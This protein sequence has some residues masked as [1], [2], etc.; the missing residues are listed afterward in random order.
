MLSLLTHLQVRGQLTARELAQRLEVDERTVQRDVQ[1]LAAAGVPVRSVRGPAGGYRLEGGYRTRLNGVGPDEAAA[2]AFLG[3]HGPAQ[4]LGLSKVLDAARTKVL[5]SL[6]GEARQRAQ[7]SADRFHL[8]PVRWYGRP[9]PTPRLADLADAVWRDRRARIG[10]VRRGELADRTID[11]LGLA[12]ASG[13]WYLVALRDGQ[14]R[15]YRVSRVRTVEVLDEPVRRPADFVL[16]EAW[17]RSRREMETQHVCVEVTLRVATAVLPRLR[18]V[19]AV[20]GQ[21][22]IDLTATGDEIELTVPFEGE[23]W[24]CTALLGLGPAVEVLAPASLR[25]RMAV[26]S[27]AIAARYEPHENPETHG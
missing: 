10:Y 3:M 8:D 24:A 5:A 22:R 6:T 1:A 23:S 25:T 12:L 26:Q 16:A 9:E 7:R 11:P 2:L 15:T 18:R 21:D 4:D 14:R 17:A 19:V 13:D 27:R 20:E